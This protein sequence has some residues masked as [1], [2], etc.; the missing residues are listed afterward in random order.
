MDR[1]VG[2][3]TEYGCLL[4][5]E[6]LHCNSEVWPAKVKNYL[7]NK[8]RAGTIDLHYRNY[9]EPP[10]NAGFSSYGLCSS[11]RQAATPKA[12]VAPSPF[13]G[14]SPPNISHSVFTSTYSPP[15]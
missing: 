5:S 9:E 2:V 3:E 8:A 12:A 7:F 1:I 15:L 10:G 13:S 6:E 11:S 14:Y 4:S